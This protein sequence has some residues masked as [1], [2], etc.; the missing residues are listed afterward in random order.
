MS[1]Y[2]DMF[3]HVKKTNNSLTWAW[4][5]QGGLKIQKKKE[6]EKTQQKMKKK[7]KNIYAVTFGWKIMKENHFIWKN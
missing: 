7:Q 4:T 1:T 2:K 3:Y 5:P 6:K